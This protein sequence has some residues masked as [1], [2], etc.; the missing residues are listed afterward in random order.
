MGHASAPGDRGRRRAESAVAAPRVRT[1]D[2]HG[3][4]A[5]SAFGPSAT[6]D[7]TSHQ[8]VRRFELGEHGDRSHPSST[9]ARGAPSSGWIWS[10]APTRP[11]TPIRDAGQQRLIGRL[12]PRLHRQP[13]LADR[14]SARRSAATCARGMRSIAARTG[15]SRSKP[16]PSS[17]TSRRSSGAS[18]EK[19]ETAERRALFL[20]IADTVGT[21]LRSQR[22]RRRS[23]ISTRTL[24]ETL[25]R[26]ADGDEP[27]ARAIV[28]L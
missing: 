16:R 21:A 25:R 4:G 6:H 13:S 20:L 15:S 22:R 24:D 5:G 9:L 17:T 26:L 19:F 23:P 11:V 8:Q 10:F 18:T 1:T 7:E 12:R 14:G 28:F 27:P 3:S 2:W